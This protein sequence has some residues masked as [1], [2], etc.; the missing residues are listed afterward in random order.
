MT[1]YMF[2]PREQYPDEWEA[3]CELCDWHSA[4]GSERSV[5]STLNRHVATKVHQKKKAE[6]DKKTEA[7]VD[8]L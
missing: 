5:T 6:F 4:R 2:V 3:V 8:R 7:L 1:Y